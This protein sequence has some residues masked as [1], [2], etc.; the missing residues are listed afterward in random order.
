M[1]CDAKTFKNGNNFLES[2]IEIR[3][4]CKTAEPVTLANHVPV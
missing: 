3:V 1:Q 4:A 2:F